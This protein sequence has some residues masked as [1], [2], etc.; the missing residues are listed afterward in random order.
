VAGV[1]VVAGVAAVAAVAC[2]GAIAKLAWMYSSLE[3]IPSLFP[4]NIYI[5]IFALSPSDM[6]PPFLP[7]YII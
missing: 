7:I 6:L 3:T 4:S 1:A 2:G 5:I